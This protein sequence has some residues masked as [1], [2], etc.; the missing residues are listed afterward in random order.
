MSKRPRFSLFERLFHVF[1]FAL[2]FSSNFIFAQEA[3]SLRNALRSG[4]VAD[5]MK[6]NILGK[7]VLTFENTN[8]DSMILLANEGIALADKINFENGKAI[9]QQM[10]G[11]A[12]LHLN[13]HEK[14]LGY[15]RQA[16]A[17]FEKNNNK[18]RQGN[19]LLSMADIFYRQVKYDQAI[20]F[21]NKGIGI[22]K[23]LNNSMGQ[24]FALISI[25]GIYNDQSNF[26]EA[27]DYY[28]KALTAFEKDS[29]TPGICM[30]LT[31]IAT[32]YS[33][34]GD[35][36][37]ALEYINKSLQIDDSKSNKEQQALNLGNIAAVYSAIKDYNNALLFYNKGL[38]MA[39]SIGDDAWKVNMLGNIADMH[40]YMQHYDTARAT[41]EA[42][43]KLA[44]K[45]SDTSALISGNRGI[46]RT[47]IKTGD[48][49][50]GIGRLLPVYQL[51]Q[52]KQ[53]KQILFE[54][55]LDLSDA[56]EIEHD[57]AH[58]LQ[59]HK[60]YSDGKDSLFNEKNG[61]RIQQLQ[62]DYDLGKKET[63][64]ELLKKDQAIAQGKSDKQKVI[65]AALIIGLGLLIA[66]VI[67]LN[68]SRT[69]EKHS[70][71]EIMNQKEEIQQQATELEE[72]NRFKDK[73]FSVLSHDLRSPIN[74]ITSTVMLLDSNIISPEEFN[75]LRPEFNK[76]LSSLNI[77]MDNLLNWAKGYIQGK[78]PAKPEKVD[79]S[80]TV[81]RNLQLLNDTANDKQIA[82][83]NEV[84]PGITAFCDPGQIDIVIRN[85][86]SNAIKFSNTNGTVN[87]SA[88]TRDDKVRIT[89]A[90]NGIGMTQE[91]LNKIFTVTTDNSTRGTDGE[92]G[93]GLGLLLC[94]E[95]VIANNG[96]ISATSEV[97]K[98]STFVVELPKSQTTSA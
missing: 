97:N 87:I 47:L 39:E 36:K 92:R 25:G 88:A 34:L 94:Y 79:I 81:A 33:S 83:V 11:L 4:T 45:I 98:G 40:Y 56:Y 3:D 59:Y 42:E 55:A 58:A 5:T 71:E 60:I 20:E 12:Y 49:R 91:Q 67:I 50:G 6:V 17:T 46:G 14:S 30:S 52:K 9:C 86:L 65:T 13:E 19:I 85:L 73:T 21:Y 22:Y 69:Y 64:I 43:L 74:S 32:V 26:A 68:R 37:K 23:Q 70:K 66:I 18:R 80:E 96:T 95:F 2:I 28:L 8:T 31:T 77:L 90:D 82:L 10:L 41:Y 38:V 84:E 54:T 78:T 53:L 44:A 29:Y 48:I 24:G 16:L 93:I 89:I 62:Y 75:A 1:A 51:V 15:Y 7:L 72:L 61:K 57:Y 35:H 27:I 63:L 76:Q